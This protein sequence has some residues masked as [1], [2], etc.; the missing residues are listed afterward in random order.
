VD[1][2]PEAFDSPETRSTIDHELDLV[3]SAIDFVLA[4]G[5]TRV[6]L[7]GLRFG[8]EIMSR[9]SNLRFAGRVRLE[10]LWRFD[11]SGCDIAVL[12]DG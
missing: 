11:S 3:D 6:T 5:A 10:P 2:V 1:D 8:R 7:A 4:G 9:P 12:A